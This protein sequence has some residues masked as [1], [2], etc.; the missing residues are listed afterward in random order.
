MISLSKFSSNTNPK[1]PVIVA[2][3]N[4]S[5]VMWDLIFQIRDTIMLRSS[6]GILS[7]FKV[8]YN[9]HLYRERNELPVR[10]TANNTHC[11]RWEPSKRLFMVTFLYFLFY[12]PSIWCSNLH[13]SLTD[14]WSDGLSINIAILYFLR[15]CPEHH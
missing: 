14:V 13:S 2:F 11:G 15:P 4:F 12:S 5:D 1:W 6:R 8:M 7:T 10:Q 9:E 3:S